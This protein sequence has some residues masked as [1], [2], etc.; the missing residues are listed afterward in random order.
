GAG[1]GPLPFLRDAPAQL[2]SE[3]PPPATE[4]VAMLAPEPFFVYEAC[5]ALGSL[6]SGVRCEGE[7]AKRPLTSEQLGRTRGPKG[8]DLPLLPPPSLPLSALTEAAAAL[9]SGALR[10]SSF[11]RGRLQPIRELLTREEPP[12]ISDL[13]ELIMVMAKSEEVRL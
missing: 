9:G 1:N 6:G 10:R 12:A 13:L 2:P 11:L 8:L 3:R 4:S 5:V 7:R